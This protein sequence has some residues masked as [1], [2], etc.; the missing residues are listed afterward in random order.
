MVE[1]RTLEEQRNCGHDFILALF[2]IECIFI[3]DLDRYC[4]YVGYH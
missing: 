1:L 2:E 3:N 4:G